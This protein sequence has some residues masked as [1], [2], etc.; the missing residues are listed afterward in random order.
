M[1]PTLTLAL[2]WLAFAATHVAMSSLKLRPQLVKLLTPGGFL[3]VYSLVAFA[4]LF[5]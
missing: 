3:G 5:R 1:S 2:L 4:P